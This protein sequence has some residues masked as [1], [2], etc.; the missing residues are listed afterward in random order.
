MDSARTS[1]VLVLKATD[2]YKRF[3]D[4]LA[5]DNIGF[6]AAKGEILGIVG[7]NGAGKSTVIG[8]L[9]GLLEPDAGSIEIFGL[10]FARHRAG[11]LQRMNI[12]SP[13]ASLPGQLTVRQNL[14]IY[15]GLYG[16]PHPARRIADL[17]ELFGIT[18]LADARFSKLSSGQAIRVCLCKALLNQPELLLLDEPTVYLDA[19]IAARTRELILQQRALRSMT[20]L[21]TSHDLAE[22]EHLCDRI[23]LLNH[24]RMAACGSALEVTRAILGLDREHAA[25]GEVFALVARTRA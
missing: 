15:A 3:D 22:I 19:E 17:L 5:V 14:S 7:P 4:K 24:G 1:A 18:A 9:S 6:S 16:V 12:A 8:M 10:N 2:L 25:L 21:L 20:V 13:Y 23:V 11:I